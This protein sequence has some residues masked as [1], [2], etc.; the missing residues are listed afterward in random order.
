MDVRVNHKE[1][2]APNNW[3]FWIVAFESPLDCKKIKP[4]NPKENQPWIFTGRTDAEAPILWPP[5]GKNW[6]IG[7]NSDAGKDWRQNE[8]EAAEDEIDSITDSVDMNLSKLWEIVKDREAWHA[9][10]HGVAKSQT[11]LSN[12]TTTNLC[13]FTKFIFLWINFVN[14]FTNLCETTIQDSGESLE[15]VLLNLDDTCYQLLLFNIQF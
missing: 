5:D 4:V 14:K 3:C 2:W 1:G 7:K 9:A 11:Q 12:W 6:L 15:A 8:K 13:E 10:I